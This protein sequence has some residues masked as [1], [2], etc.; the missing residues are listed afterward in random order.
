[1]TAT[2]YDVGL[3]HSEYLGMKEHQQ[4]DWVEWDEYEELLYLYNSLVTK[5]ESLWKDI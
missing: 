3:N 5:V 2:R 1:M 4:G